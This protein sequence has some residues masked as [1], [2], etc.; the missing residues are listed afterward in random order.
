MRN[1][2]EKYNLGVKRLFTVEWSR[3]YFRIPCKSLG[4][5]RRKS[6]HSEYEMLL[7]RKN[8]YYL[9]FIIKIKELTLMTHPGP[10]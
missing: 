7:I 5:R 6:L 4:A 9:K 8:Y 10:F 1:L 2:P 3:Q